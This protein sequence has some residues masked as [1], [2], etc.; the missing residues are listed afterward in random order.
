M[1]MRIW[2]SKT[3]ILS[4]KGPF[5]W[6]GMEDMVSKILKI[7]KHGSLRE[8]TTPF[9]HNGWPWWPFHALFVLCRSPVSGATLANANLA[10]FSRTGMHIFTIT[11]QVL[12]AMNCPNVL[13]SLVAAS[14]TLT[15]GMCIVEVITGPL[16]GPPRQLLYG[17]RAL[18]THGPLCEVPPLRTEA[19]VYGVVVN[20][21]LHT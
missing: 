5:Q 10:Q 17:H 7:I 9:P 3:T 1:R 8:Q 13:C 20:S 11:K 6:V 4:Q 12:F 19:V 18:P 16:A 2:V 21:N 15:K 14:E